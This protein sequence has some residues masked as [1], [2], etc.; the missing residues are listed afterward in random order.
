VAF[1][2]ISRSSAKYLAVIYDQNG[3]G[4]FVTSN[5]HGRQTDAGEH[6]TRVTVSKVTTRDNQHFIILCG[7]LGRN[8]ENPMVSTPIRMFFWP[9]SVFVDFT[10]AT[11]AGIIWSYSFHFIQ[12]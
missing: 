7:L 3:F 12:Q 10:E 1:D 4:H 2:E 5:V 6:L 8:R 9:D 11:I